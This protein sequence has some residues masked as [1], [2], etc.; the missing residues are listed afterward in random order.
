MADYF[1]QYRLAPPKT[2]EQRVSA[3]TPKDWFSQFSPERHP[4]NAP[5]VGR[6][7]AESAPALMTALFP[8]APGLSTLSGTFLNTLLKSVSPQFFGSPPGTVEDLAGQAAKD[9]VVNNLIPRAVSAGVGGV[10]N[11]IRAAREGPAAFKAY[12]ASTPLFSQAPG[13]RQGIAKQLSRDALYQYARPESQIVEEAAGR[14]GTSAAIHNEIVQN[15]MRDEPISLLPEPVKPEI[16]PPLKPIRPAEV[17]SSDLPELQFPEP[18][19]KPIEYKSTPGQNLLDKKAYD[20]ALANHK[21]TVKSIIEN[22]KAEVDRINA[23]NDALHQKNLTEWRVQVNDLT[24]AN[25]EAHTAAQEAYKVQQQK[26]KQGVL[27]GPQTD[28]ALTKYN[29]MFGEGTI[30]QKLLKMDDEIQK[31]TF[32]PRSQTYRDISTEV[33]KDPITVRAL[34]ATGGPIAGPKLAQDFAFHKLLTD[35]TGNETLNVK[36]ILQKLDSEGTREVYQ[37]A[38]RPEVQAEF[39]NLL[40]EIQQQSEGKGIGNAL[41]RYSN[42]KLYWASVGLGALSHPGVAA[43]AI[44]GAGLVKMTNSMLTRAMESPEVAQLVIQAMRTPRD[45]AMSPMIDKALQVALR[46]AGAVETTPEK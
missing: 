21:Q 12:V 42:H 25:E 10:A 34:K 32:T 46:G 39:R 40:G 5:Y 14:A 24:K 18:P 36:G 20:E 16:L 11:A 30:G 38:I 27:F 13:V 26:L 17:K 41:V 3:A 31:G 15:A 6:L 29:E 33:M 22:R 28:E 2:L 43:K 19:T 8:E 37:E 4:E 7:T 45:S 9:Q 35:E 1:D 23:A 44:A